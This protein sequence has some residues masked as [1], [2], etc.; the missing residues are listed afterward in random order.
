MNNSTRGNSE[1]NITNII[2]DFL[3]SG[4]LKY[5]RYRAGVGWIIGSICVSMIVSWGLSSMEWGIFIGIFGQ[6]IFIY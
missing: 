1:S 5:G 2:N 3:Y 6:R 4:K